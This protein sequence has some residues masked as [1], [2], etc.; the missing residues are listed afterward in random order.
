M[1]YTYLKYDVNPGTKNANTTS[2]MIL[3]LTNG[4]HLYD[5]N[6]QMVKMAIAKNSGINK[7]A[8]EINK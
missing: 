1:G 7:G 6:D 3:P 4:R 5:F 2:V 8:C